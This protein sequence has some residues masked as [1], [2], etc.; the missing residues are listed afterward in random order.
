MKFLHS[1]ISY[2]FHPIFVPVVG[3]AIYFV[4]TPQ[5]TPLAV[6]T[7][8]LLPI[9]ILTVIIPL[10]FYLILRNLGIVSSFFL[11]ST[12][13]RKYPLFIIIPLL[14]MILYKVIPNNYT[15]ELFHYF[16][17]LVA[18]CLSCLLLLF[19][20]FKSSIHL[21]GM[22]SILMF[23]ISLSIHFETNV[24]IALSAFTFATGLV[25]SSK[26]YL[27]THSRGELLVGFL[28]GLVSQLLTLKFWL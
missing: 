24:I 12:K 14:L 5:Y 25:A 20:H 18:A 4:I 3:T 27:G 9:F 13:E 21:M 10:I 23:L 26:L 11:P 19:F 22:G 8:N 7:G 17:G 16:L 1:A 15:T 6:I 2:F 28:I